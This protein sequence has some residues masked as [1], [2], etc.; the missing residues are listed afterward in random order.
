MTVNLKDWG[1][2]AGWETQATRRAE[3]LL[4]GRV[5]A[6]SRH[7]F[8]V[9]AEPGMSWCRPTGT[10]SGQ[11]AGTS[12]FP[13]TGDWVLVEHDPSYTEWPIHGMLPRRSAL[14]RQ[15]PA[16]S[17]HVADE[18]VLAANIDYVF[19]VCGL[20][21]GRNF[22]ERG[23]ERYLTAAWQSGAL[24]VVVLNKSDLAEDADLSILQ[25]GAVA[26]GVDVV[27]TSTVNPGGLDGLGRY[28]LAGKTVALVGRSGVGKSTIVNRLVGEEILATRE[29]RASDLR[30]RHT[31]SLRRLV[32]LP[33]GSLLLDTPGLRSLALWGD[34]GAAD[35]AFSDIA[36]IAEMCQFRDCAHRGEPGCAVQQALS[37]GALDAAR[38]ESYLAQ[39]KELRYL[40]QK[41]DLKTRLAAKSDHKA[42]SLHIRRWK[43]PSGKRD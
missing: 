36:E 30:G 33:T 41:Q 25:A 14:S 34:E 29:N 23:V 13:V 15:A 5:V 42:L 17:T 28:L 27:A 9:V 37:E 18:Q 16:D 3:G 22:T 43:R 26:P 20:D 2:D 19:I 8:Q 21:G 4:P 38:Y 40:A 6:D 32:R 11:F 7:L 24:P 35:T 39:Q 1:W 31:T 12:A 10:F